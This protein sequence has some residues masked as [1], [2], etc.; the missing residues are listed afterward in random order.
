MNQRRT[1]LR[2]LSLQERLAGVF[3]AAALSLPAMAVAH[4]KV[5][6]VELPV[7]M[8]G[9][10]AVATMK[11]NGSDV[12]M[13]VD[14][15]AFFSGLTDAIAAQLQL[16]TR[17]L[18]A[19]V[20]I[21][22]ATGEIE[23]RLTTVKSLQMLD[24]E[25][26]NV[27]FL[28]GGNNPGSGTVGLLG[29]NVLSITDAEY[30][31]AHGAFRF[32]FPQGDCG[33]RNMAYWAGQ[34]PVHEVDM[35]RDNTY[36]PV[37][38]V[39]ARLN[40]RNARV[41]LDTGAP[42]TFVSRRFAY[43][44]GVTEADMAP[45]GE[46]GGA[47]KGRAKAWVATFKTF[48]LGGEKIENARM[49]VADLDMFDHDVILGIDF[50]LSHRLYLSKEQRRMYFTYN[51]GPVF[52]T[53]PSGSTS[54]DP[55]GVEEPQDA[56]GFARRGAARASRRDYARALEDFNRACEMAPQVADHFLRRG[57]VHRALKQLPQA[58]QD[59]DTA[60]SLDARH[61]EALWERVGLRLAGRD[62]TGALDDLQTMDGAL[63]PQAHRRL[64]MAKVYASLDLYDK[65]L[66]Q[67]NQWIPAHL[68]EEGVESALN[69]RCWARAML[70]TELDEAIQDCDKALD[71]QPKNPHFL[72]SRGWARLRRGD[73]REALK[74]YERALKL[75]PDLAWTLY[76][77]GLVR[78]RLGEVEAGRADL[79]AARKLEADIDVQA[80]RYGLAAAP[81]AVAKP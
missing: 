19:N 37:P 64:A 39:M 15:G 20:T 78:I 35:L 13:T 22:G 21:R 65:T 53:D 80:G 34:T 46:V 43:R 2:S 26:P 81:A 31:F 57:Q 16:P 27:E 61:P 3:I 77:R 79:E 7:T 60:L 40:G 23:Q 42:A 67:L 66:V 71:L 17:P 63:A 69:D 75:K 56:A 48:E 50:F 74:D 62:R 6:S 8:V 51:G 25:V 52:A 1:V 38:A 12:R 18:P 28:V 49:M 76:G 68:N 41:M 47:G 59:V 33:D 58:R 11:I 44:L 14:S 55:V 73:D 29:R 70:G 4:C 32:M 10:R 36:R 9:K 72:D 5:G 30:D 54:T 24:G 45:A